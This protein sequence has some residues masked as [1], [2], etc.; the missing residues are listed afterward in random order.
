MNITIREAYNLT[1]RR[2]LENVFAIGIESKETKLLIYY[3]YLSLLIISLFYFFSVSSHSIE[4]R[5]FIII[6][7]GISTVILNYLYIKNDGKKQRIKILIFIETIC[8]CFILLTSGG[9]NSPYVWYTMN[10]IM[11]SAIKLDRNYCL[12]NLSIYLFYPMAILFSSSEIVSLSLFQ[13]IKR[14]SNLI[15]S[16][17]LM[18]IAILHLE[19]LTKNIQ[20]KS[21]R[22]LKINGQLSSANRTIQESMEHIMDLYQAVNS[23]ANHRDHNKL[24]ELFIHYSKVITKSERVFFMDVLHKNR[25]TLEDEENIHGTLENRFREKILTGWYDITENRKPT[26]LVIENN[27]YVLIAVKSTYRTYG[28]LGIRESS[29]KEAFFYE[30][31][32]SNQIVFLA[33]LG[34]MVLERSYIEDVNERLI[35]T[36]EQNRIAN[37]I[38]DSVLQR[39][40]SMALN[41]FSIEKNMDKL[42]ISQIKKELNL[43]RSSINSAM[44]ELRSTIYGLSWKKNGLNTFKEDIL[45]YINEIQ[46]F[47]DTNITF[48]ITGTYEFLSIGQKKALYRVICEGI[49]NAL[50]HG[51]PANIKGV[52]DI[53][54]DMNHLEITDDGVGFNMDHI[55]DDKQTGLGLRNMK[56][57]LETLNGNLQI[58]S[59]IGKGT[60]IIATFPNGVQVFEEEEAV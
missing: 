57:L 36:Q 23:L 27:P 28:I 14:N 53:Q 20:Q 18:T 32:I 12:F 15:M 26:R 19:K 11:T 13:G 34:S 7:I 54:K 16:F 5:I 60:S 44:V 29:H 43:V 30:E 38:H 42:G 33:E 40:F 59:I 6:C 48:E 17:I 56:Y 4:K 25:I 58:N 24:I 8:N 31:S 35:I 55:K 3:R 52:L 47:R 21:E 2:F 45:R 41:I 49:G 37:E 22:M 50:R 9:I 46:G 10:T 51:R 39:L 1:F